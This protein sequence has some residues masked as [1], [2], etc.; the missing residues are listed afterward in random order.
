MNA[1]SSKIDKRQKAKLQIKY[2][3]RQKF[4]LLYLNI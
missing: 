1:A 3:E 4:E 2:P